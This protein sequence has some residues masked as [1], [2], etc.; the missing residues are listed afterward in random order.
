M[1]SSQ[2]RCFKQQR[3]CRISR[4]LGVRALCK[5]ELSH[6]PPSAAGLPGCRTVLAGT[7]VSSAAQLE[8]DPPYGD[9]GGGRN[10]VPCGCR[11]DGIRLSRRPEQ[12]LSSWRSS[13]PPG[14]LRLPS[15][16]QREPQASRTLQSYLWTRSHL[17]S[18]TLTVFC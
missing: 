13:T 7:P 12:P 11:G 17:C 4:F 16:T 3:T 6:R 1:L 2:T 10:C 5:A 14:H 15:G 8:K 9:S 18:I